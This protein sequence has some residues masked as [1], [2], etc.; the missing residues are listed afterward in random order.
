MSTTRTDRNH[1]TLPNSNHDQN[2]DFDQWVKAVKPQLMAALRAN[3]PISDIHKNGRY[4]QK[5]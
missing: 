1:T 4:H 2:F 3:H 5:R